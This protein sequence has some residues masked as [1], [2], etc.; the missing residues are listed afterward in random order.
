M[1]KQILCPIDGSPTSD[2]GMNEAINLAKDQN[3]KLRFLH[4]IDLY[5][6]ILDATGDL[7]M[8]YIDETLRRNGKKVLKRAE[9]SAHRAGVDSDSKEIEALNNRVSECIVEEARE[10]SADLIV[11]GTHGLRGIERLVMG[12]DAETVIRT[13]PVPVLLMRYESDTENEK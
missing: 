4:V 12:S 9:D 8:V 7:N 10:W 6:P 11:M 13:S 5:F 2:C 1:Y 3:A